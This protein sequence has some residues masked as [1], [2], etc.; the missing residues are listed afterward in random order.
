MISAL[1]LTVASVL[2]TERLAVI[3]YALWAEADEFVLIYK[4]IFKTLS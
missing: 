3:H 1:I 4:R 2:Y